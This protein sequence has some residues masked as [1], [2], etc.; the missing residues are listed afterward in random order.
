MSRARY[1]AALSASCIASWSVPITWLHAVMRAGEATS[2]WTASMA[3]P[4]YVPLA[5]SVDVADL[6]MEG[7]VEVQRAA[8]GRAADRTIAALADGGL[9]K[10]S[11]SA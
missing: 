6:P 9:Y 10:T 5:R 8:N 11:K 2:L 7:I 3:V 4:H 1:E